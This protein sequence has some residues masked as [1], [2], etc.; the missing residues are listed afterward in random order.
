MD[1]ELPPKVHV[2]TRDGDVGQVLCDELNRLG[3]LAYTA[4]DVPVAGPV[5]VVVSDL[6]RIEATRLAGLPSAETAGGNEQRHVGFVGL[7]TA[8]WADVTLPADSSPREIWLTC[9]LVAQIV[10]LRAQR[11]AALLRAAEFERLSQLDALTGV[12][13]RRA[14]DEQLHEACRSPGTG[15]WVA[16]VDLDGFKAVNGALGHPAGDDV[17]RRVAQAMAGALTSGRL[18]ARLGGDEFGVLL[19]DM[20]EEDAVTVLDRLC[21]VVRAAEL[22]HGCAPLSASI[23]VV[24]VGGPEVQPQ[25]VLIAADRALRAAKQAGG[26]QVVR[27]TIG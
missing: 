14:W 11:N 9:T 15:G 27:G 2:A 3:A 24:A 23:G 26:D 17:L 19:R 4:G 25:R 10:R 6:P 12:A 21:A 8:T 7:G 16:L 13:N 20:D 1:L 5:E 22:P 18:L